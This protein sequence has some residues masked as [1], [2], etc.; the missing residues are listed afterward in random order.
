LGV[1]RTFVETSGRPAVLLCCEL[2]SLHLQPAS[3][4]T[5]QI[6]SHSL[7]ADAAAAVV[8]TPEP[9]GY[10][11]RD[12]ASV[13]DTSAS[14]H[15]T[16]EVTDHGFRMGLSPRVP[17]VLAVH[18]ESFVDGVLDR[19]DL[20]RDDIDGWA[21]HPGGPRILDVVGQKLDLP[22]SAL[23]VSRRVLAEHG[24]CSSP[25]VLM[26]LDEMRRQP[27]PPKRVLMLAFGPGLT[28]YAAL[29]GG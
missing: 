10:A 1:A 24:N 13:T 29:L 11:I 14:D 9:K 20:T 2:T 19:H 4:S 12:I 15:M 16:W 27:E 6:V 3:A 21:V 28:L 26:I 25:T 22:P 8:V 17:D 7:F 23:D 5:E 18:I